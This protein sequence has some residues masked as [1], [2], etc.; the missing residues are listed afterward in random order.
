MILDKYCIF[1]VNIDIFYSKRYVLL[2]LLV[3][4]TVFAL[5][6]NRAYTA[7][8]QN[9]KLLGKKTDIFTVWECTTVNFVWCPIIFGWAFET[10]SFKSTPILLI[11]SKS[12]VFWPWSFSAIDEYAQNYTSCIGNRRSVEIRCRW[13]RRRDRASNKSCTNGTCPVLLEK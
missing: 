9:I 7:K 5:W 1:T 12:S 2:K 8:V 3:G 13:W 10:T 4:L 6:S 11:A